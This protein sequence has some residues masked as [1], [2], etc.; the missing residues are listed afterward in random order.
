MPVG[1]LVRHLQ[2]QPDDQ[3]DLEGVLEQL[4]VRGV[5]VRT[6]DG[7]VGVPEKMNLLSGVLT[8][9]PDGY[10]FVR[11][12]IGVES[13]DLFV[14]GRKMAAAMHGDRVVARVEHVRRSGRLEGRVIRVLERARQTVVG[15]FERGKHF[16]Y[17]VPLDPRA[18][19]D[20]YIPSEACDGTADGQIVHVE[21]TSFPEGSRNPE[22]KILEVLGPA[23]DP[24]ID[25]EIVIREYGLPPEFPPEVQAAS[26]QIAGE[27]GEEELQN[28]TDFRD[29]PVVTIDGEKAQ[30]FDDAVF[31]EP[32]PR[33]GYRLAV[34]IADVAYYVAVGSIV[35][36]EAEQRATSVYFPDH[37]LPM[38]PEPLSNGI[39]SLKPGVDR[40]VQSVVIDIDA[41]GKTVNYDFHDG[42]IRSAEQLTYEQAASLLE[43]AEPAEKLA[44]H[45]EHLQH[46]KKLCSILMEY[47]RRRGSL[48]F[49]LPEPELLINLRGEVETI[50]AAERNIAHRIIEEFMIRANEV[51]ASHLQWEAVPTL[52]RVHEGPDPEG[53][54][55][56][57]EFV[58]GLGYRLGGG[59]QPKTRHFSDLLRSLEGQPE[60]LMLSLLLL[61]AMKQARY[62]AN[63][64]GHFGLA[65]QRYTH[66]TSPIRRYPDLI[67]HRMLRADR[68]S[69]CGPAFDVDDLV[70]RFDAIGRD[71][72]LQERRAESAERDYVNLKKVQFMAEK[73]GED[74][75]GYITGVQ[76]FG[77]FVQLDSF[78][79]E[80][81]VHVSSLDDDYY[82]FE[83]RAHALKGEHTKRCFGLGDRVTVRV[84]KVDVER[85]RIDFALQAGPLPSAARTKA[86]STAPGKE[87]PRSTRRRRRRP[88]GAAARVQRGSQES[89][90]KPKESEDK[91]TAV[92]PEQQRSSKTSTETASEK[93]RRRRPAAARKKSAPRTTTQ[94][95]ASGEGRAAAPQSAKEP[96]RRPRSTR[97]G[98]GRRRRSRPEADVK[99]AAKQEPKSRP[100]PEKQR[101]ARINPYL[102]DVDP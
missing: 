5:V 89:G 75:D 68:N 59:E 67:V 28:R 83:E 73:V 55:R 27:V 51:V 25:I 48:D 54:Q 102:T 37:V 43:D 85:K 10:G 8:A 7:R 47:R 35:D 45:R 26:E 15:R 1:S 36:V 97:G 50:G 31:V 56:F 6:R 76:S 61:R 78:F 44:G 12:E 94:E 40:L 34:H 24:N 81:L 4:V 98:S 80:G 33:G 88:A 19:H 72:S 46:M 42:V 29:L 87:K 23:G 90:E 57:R 63:N 41:D 17:V 9:H 84:A 77:F 11:S 20:V 14:P 18:I 38:L 74:Y 96:S 82:R 66:F 52:Y 39:C 16:G 99:P 79:V 70:S 95:P 21:I 22:G 93:P 100:E 3:P 91:I 69:D 101:P 64:E 30:D 92:A 62:Q 53:V 60:E 58:V 32:L 13:G 65:S 2:L 49:D 86:E 71:S